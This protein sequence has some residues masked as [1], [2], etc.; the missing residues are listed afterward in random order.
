MVGVDRRVGQ[1]RLERSPVLQLEEDVAVPDAL[2]LD[3]LPRQ[4]QAGLEVMGAGARG[5]EEVAPGEV[6]LVAAVRVERL[7]LGGVDAGVAHDVADGDVGRLHLRLVA[8][9]EDAPHAAEP[10]VQHHPPAEHVVVLHDVVLRRLVLQH[11][12]LVL[13]DQVGRVAA[14]EAIVDV[15][16]EEER[17]ADGRCGLPGRLAHEVADR[18]SSMA[19]EPS[20]LLAPIWN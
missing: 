11:G 16:V 18:L 19:W 12:R 5:V 17:R 6:A 9:R 8:D 4:L 1:L 15:L 13:D 3:T 20:G 10:R 2:V 7:R 14:M